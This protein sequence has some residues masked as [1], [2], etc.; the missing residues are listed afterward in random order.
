VVALD[1]AA[2]NSAASAW[3]G[4]EWQYCHTTRTV[5]ASRLEPK[6]NCR[7]DH[8]RRWQNV[9]RL[10]EDEATLTLR[11]LFWAAGIALDA[12]ARIR[13]CQQIAL[14]GRCVHCHAAASVLRW[15]TDPHAPVATCDAC[16]GAVYPVPFTI[17]SETSLEP[18]LNVL[19]QP[20]NQWG[21]ERFA[22]F[23]ISRGGRCVTFVV[24]A[25]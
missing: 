18:L 9:V 17:F 14:R 12:R 22:V 4:Q 5:R 21:V 2:D 16:A 20:L 6:R 8:T 7:W 23:E 25:S 24:G 1:L 15:I 13:F 3:F 11:E 19:D 10:S